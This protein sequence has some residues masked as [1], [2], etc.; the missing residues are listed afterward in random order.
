M[1]TRTHLKAIE[2]TYSVE[3]YETMPTTLTPCICN[4]LRDIVCTLI[5]FNN[6]SKAE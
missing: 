1:I 4:L 3:N 2:F 6:D 5:N